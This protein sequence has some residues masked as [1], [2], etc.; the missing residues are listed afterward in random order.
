[1]NCSALLA[2]VQKLENDRFGCPEG[3]DA[4]Q[5][6]CRARTEVEAKGCYSSV[7]KWTPSNYYDQP[8]AGRAKILGAPNT[9]HLCK[10]LLLENKKCPIGKGSP[11][12]PRFVMVVVQYEATLNVRKLS[13]AVRALKPVADRVDY[14]SFDFRVASSEDND[15]LTGFKHN[16]VAPFGLVGKDNEKDGM[17]MVLAEA[18]VPLRFFWMGG[19]HVRLKLGMSVPEFVAASGAIVA[20]ISEPRSG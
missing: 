8:I 17:L 6:M 19:G 5:S 1:M 18:I 13:N 11:T 2:R 12:F 4:D 3:I 10:S 15:R 9:M 7:W 16:A 14:S 20:D